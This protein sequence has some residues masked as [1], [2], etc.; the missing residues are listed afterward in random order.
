MRCASQI[1]AAD[2]SDKLNSEYLKTKFEF[3]NQS[4]NFLTSFNIPRKYTVN[5]WLQMESDDHKSKEVIAIETDVSESLETLR[6]LLE[7]QLHRPLDHFE[8]W[9]QDTMKVYNVVLLFC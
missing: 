4:S 8:F 3:I 2:C 5:V 1:H 6:K 7:S 9:L